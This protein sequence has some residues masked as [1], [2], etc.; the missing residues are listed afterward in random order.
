M[1]LRG[2]RVNGLAKDCEWQQGNSDP[3]MLLN[4]PLS[5]RV[6]FN[7]YTDG[8]KVIQMHFHSLR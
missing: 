2:T 3:E 6:R 5:A 7:C 1:Q 4:C 8:I